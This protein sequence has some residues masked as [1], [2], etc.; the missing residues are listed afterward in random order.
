[1][2]EPAVFNDVDKTFPKSNLHHGGVE[3]REVH[4]LYGHKNSKATFQALRKTRPESEIPFILTR[5][6]YAGT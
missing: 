2:N 4:N 3:H 5:S 6:F 1:M